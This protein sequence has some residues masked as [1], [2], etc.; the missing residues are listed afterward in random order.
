[1]THQKFIKAGQFD[2]FCALLF[3]NF[4]G[5]AVLDEHG[6]VKYE[7]EDPDKREAFH[8]QTKV[9]ELCWMCKRKPYTVEGSVDSTPLCIGCNCTVYRQIKSQTEE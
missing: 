7:F 5:R 8:I 4:G 1:M 2:S 9:E 3:N 6:Y